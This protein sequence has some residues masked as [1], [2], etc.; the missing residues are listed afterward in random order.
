MPPFSP[1]DADG[2]NRDAQQASS[3]G[4]FRQGHDSKHCRGSAG[5][6]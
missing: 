3:E 4:T 6:Q 1:G 5:E 2:T